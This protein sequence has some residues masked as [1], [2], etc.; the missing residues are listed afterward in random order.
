MRKMILAALAVF[1]L[2]VSQASAAVDLAATGTSI[3]ADI[4]AAITVGL[5]LFAALAA[6]RYAIRA[7]KASSRG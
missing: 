2:V 1:G 3:L 4:T 5:T 7:F 6:V